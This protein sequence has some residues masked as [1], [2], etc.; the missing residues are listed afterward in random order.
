MAT[1]DELH[2]ACTA[3]GACVL[4]SELEHEHAALEEERKRTTEPKDRLAFLELE[5]ASSST[6]VSKTAVR[7]EEQGARAG[8][9][10]FNLESFVLRVQALIEDDRF[11]Q[12]LKENTERAQKL[13]Q[14]HPFEE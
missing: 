12:L 8:A 7:L 6:R 10:L 4:E 14:V 9:T 5:V 11:T 3:A 2:D 1:E 13:V